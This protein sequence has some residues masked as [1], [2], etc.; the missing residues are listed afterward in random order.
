M[1]KLNIPYRIVDMCT[2][3]LGAIAAKKYD[4]EAW[5]PGRGDY[6]EVTSTSN[7]T[8]YQARN[9]N[10][11]YREGDRN[12]Y[13][14]MLNGTAIALSR[15]M[16]AILENYQNEDGSV[17]VPEVLVKWMGKKRIQKA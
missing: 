14:Y 3:E 15:I 11:K 7:T 13:V 5:M 2:G 6:G 1:Q 17:N 16:I 9:L 8:D 12:E 4:L 10:I